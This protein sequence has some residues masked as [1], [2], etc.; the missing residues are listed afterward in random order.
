LLGS[1]KLL[2]SFINN[3]NE[4]LYEQIKDQSIIIDQNEIYI[5]PYYVDMVKEIINEKYK[6]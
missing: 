6:S 1:G 3:I 2:N 5:D 4:V